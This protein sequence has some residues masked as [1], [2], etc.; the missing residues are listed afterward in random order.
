MDE[1]P[2]PLKPALKSPYPSD[3]EVVR[4]VPVTT[5]RMEPYCMTYKVCRKVPVRV[6]ECEP[7]C[8]RRLF[9]PLSWDTP[10]VGETPANDE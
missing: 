5:C 3:E 4:R 1:I 8:P 7:S 2:M 6:P 9:R 10:A